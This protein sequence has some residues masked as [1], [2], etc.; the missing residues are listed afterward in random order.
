MVIRTRKLATE[1]PS[2][3]LENCL[4][5]CYSIRY[6]GMC[7]IRFRLDATAANCL[8]NI[9]VNTH[10]NTHLNTHPH[11]GEGETF[12]IN[13]L[14]IIAYLFA[15][16][17]RRICA[18]HQRRQPSPEIAMGRMHT[19][20]PLHHLPHIATEPCPRCQSLRSEVLDAARDPLP[21]T[22]PGKRDLP[23]SLGS[24][25]RTCTTGQISNRERFLWQT[26]TQ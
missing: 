13:V 2:N 4:D 1:N 19:T 3:E 21:L 25:T 7:A 6:T 16:I 14:T 24:Y 10:V 18:C 8:S 17:P 22:S 20:V 12:L 26:R 23:F 9:H 11:S 15:S 5:N